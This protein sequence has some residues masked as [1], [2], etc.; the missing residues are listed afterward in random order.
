MTYPVLPVP[1][2]EFPALLREIPQPPTSLTYRGALPPPELSLLTAVGSRQYSSYGNQ[3]VDHLINGLRGY[4]VGIVSG[5]A[6]GIDALAHEAALRNNL[7]TLAVPGSGLNDDGLYPRTNRRL[8]QRI[9]ESGGG[10]LSEFPPETAAA[11]WTF[12]QRN[13]IMAGITP[14]TLVVEASEKSGTLITAR[15]C[16]D[17]NRELLVVPGNIFSRS[18]LGPHQFLKLGATPITASEDILAVLGIDPQPDRTVAKIHEHKDLSADE[19][20]ILNTLIEPTDRDTLLRKTGIAPSIGNTLLMSLELKGYLV[21]EHGHYRA[22][23]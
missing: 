14:A 3:V 17:Y 11:V 20:L 4:P 8:A 7:Y 16:V 19:Q 18:S 15:M 6:L 1:A 10:L 9:L 21:N 13:R 5:L 12:P 23:I 2:A 22:V